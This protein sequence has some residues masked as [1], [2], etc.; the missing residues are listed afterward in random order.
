MLTFGQR[1]HFLTVALQAKTGNY[2][3]A[4]GRANTAGWHQ[5]IRRPEDVGLDPS[6]TFLLWKLSKSRNLRA[7]VSLYLREGNS[8]PV[9]FL[10]EL[11][12]IMQ[13]NLLSPVFDLIK[14]VNKGLRS[15]PTPPPY[16]Q[17]LAF[18]SIVLY[19]NHL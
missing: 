1:L 2:R 14:A 5:G 10:W 9:G 17:G 19:T 6:S 11:H 12:D 15:F 4:G 13:V 3:G 16:P 18:C 8:F 7:W